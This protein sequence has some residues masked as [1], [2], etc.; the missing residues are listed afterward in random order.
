MSKLDRLSCIA[1]GKGLQHLDPIGVGT[2]RALAELRLMVLRAIGATEII[3]MGSAAYVIQHLLGLA[4]SRGHGAADRYFARIA[5]SKYLKNSD[6]FIS[7]PT[8]MRMM[9][10]SERLRSPRSTPPM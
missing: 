5:P 3:S 2:R 8:T 4:Q 9:F 1:G 10:V 7:S 6:G